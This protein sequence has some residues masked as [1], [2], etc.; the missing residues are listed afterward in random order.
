MAT[1][2]FMGWTINHKGDQFTARKGNFFTGYH[3]CDTT[4]QFLDILEK[5]YGRI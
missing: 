5:Q 1:Y 2:T 4:G 3:T